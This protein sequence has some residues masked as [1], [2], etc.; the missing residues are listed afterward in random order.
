MVFA[1]NSVLCLCILPFL[2]L[3]TKGIVDIN[4]VDPLLPFLFTAI[5]L[6]QAGR[7]SSQK[8][9]EYAGE[10]RRT[11]SHAAVETVINMVVSITGVIH[12]GIYGV[13][14]GTIVAL[15]YRSV[16]MIYYSCRKIL[17]IKQFTVYKKWLINLVLF[18]AFQECFTK[19]GIQPT[20]YLQVVL[21][22]G[23]LMV[24][25]FAVFGGAA[26]SYDRESCAALFAQ[27]KQRVKR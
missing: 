8:V 14:M 17:H 1:C 27:I 6:L 21:Y 15:L 23:L 20:T 24:A 3:Y 19:I 12:F 9:I 7:F 10:F 5:Q 2:K 18:A 25:A 11:Q 4:Y 26:Y 22:A 13:L 16:A